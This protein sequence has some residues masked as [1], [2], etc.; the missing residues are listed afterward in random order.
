MTFD[1][2]QTILA[3]KYLQSISL[4]LKHRYLQFCKKKSS[5]KIRRTWLN[6]E[7]YGKKVSTM[8]SLWN[9]VC[10][11]SYMCIRHLTLLRRSLPVQ[12]FTHRETSAIFMCHRRFDSIHNQTNNQSAMWKSRNR[13]IPSVTM[14]YRKCLR[15]NYFRTKICFQKCFLVNL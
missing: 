4:W 7:N 13:C 14:I 9:K 5:L 1:L 11:A 10:T 8:E 6:K 3:I 12:Q 15:S 2:D